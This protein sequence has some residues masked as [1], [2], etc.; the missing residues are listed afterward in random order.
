MLRWANS[1]QARQSKVDLSLAL[2]T[3]PEKDV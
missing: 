1:S 2:E 3:D